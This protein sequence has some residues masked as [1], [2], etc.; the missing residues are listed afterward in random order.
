MGDAV[1]DV[2]VAGVLVEIALWLVEAHRRQR[3]SLRRRDQ[4]GVVP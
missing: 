3:A 2:G 1:L 4:I